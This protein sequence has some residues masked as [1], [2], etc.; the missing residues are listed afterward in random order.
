SD[1]SPI[2]A[3]AEGQGKKSAGNENRA[4]R[5]ACPHGQREASRVPEDSAASLQPQLHERNARRHESLRERLSVR[6]D[7]QTSV[8]TQ[9]AKRS[10]QRD[11]ERF[12]S[13]DFS[14]PQHEG[15]A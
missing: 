4:V 3:K 11:R 12:G 8:Y 7:D 14:T 6:E 10:R 1:S 5:P 15:D 13:T 2:A 9:G